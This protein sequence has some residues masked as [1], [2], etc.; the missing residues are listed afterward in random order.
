MKDRSSLR[1]DASVVPV[2]M[3]SVII[4]LPDKHFVETEL[5]NICSHGIRVKIPQT[6]VMHTVPGKND[7]LKAV[8]N[9]CEMVFTGMCVYSDTTEDESVVIGIYF[10]V[11]SE[12]NMLHN[13]LQKIVQSDESVLGVE[14]I[15]IAQPFVKH[16]WEELID[17]MCHSEN[18]MIR[19]KGLHELKQHNRL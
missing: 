8:F 4:E 2:K 7:I 12:Q 19:E 10:I 3:T 11:P 13:I 16:E 6:A 17:M 18:P 9:F 5:I 14:T 15:G 1:Y